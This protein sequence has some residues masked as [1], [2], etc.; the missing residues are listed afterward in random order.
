MNSE[1]DDNLVEQCKN[2]KRE[3]FN[4]LVRRYQERVY[5]TIRRIVGD[6]DDA[7]DITQDVFVKAYENIRDFRGDAHFFTWMYRIAMNL[8]INHVRK[9]KVRAAF[10]LDSI[11]EAGDHDDR[12]PDRLMERSEMRDI[13]TAAIETLPAK[14]K[15]VFVLRYYQELSYE[16]IA[17][18]MNRTVGG[19]KANYFH[20]VRKIQEYVNHAL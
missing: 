9:R 6:R 17:G 15:A 11:E 13:I 8:A 19:L 12:E 5:W 16:E 2:G 20:A 14:Q 4:M 3:A 18:I 10:S 1:S 7:L